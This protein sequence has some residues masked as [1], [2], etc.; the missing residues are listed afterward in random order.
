MYLWAQYKATTTES[1]SLEWGCIIGMAGQEVENVA[2]LAL[3]D[4][5]YGEM[6]GVMNVSRN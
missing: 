4:S 1:E 3:I 5:C 6:S 2:L